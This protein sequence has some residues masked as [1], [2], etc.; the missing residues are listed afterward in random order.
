[1]CRSVTL[2]WTIKTADD[3]AFQAAHSFFE[4]TVLDAY[5]R[6]FGNVG[7]MVDMFRETGSYEGT[8]NQIKIEGKQPEQ[9]KL[10]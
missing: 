3:R 2:T 7:Y 10:L 5:S 8:V 6:Q 1:M 4:N 9:L